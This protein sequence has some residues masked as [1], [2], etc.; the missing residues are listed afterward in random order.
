VEKGVIVPNFFFGKT[1]AGKIVISVLPMNPEGLKFVRL[2]LTE[3]NVDEK[4]HTQNVEI[5][6]TSNSY[7]ITCDPPFPLLG[8]SP[9]VRNI[10]AEFY[11]ESNKL[12]ATVVKAFPF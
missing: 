11:D 12:V 8:S 6:G 9:F 10:V 5:L 2:L 1:S 4:N 3:T 7:T